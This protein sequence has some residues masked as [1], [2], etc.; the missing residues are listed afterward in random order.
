MKRR[1]SGVVI[2]TVSFFR[3]TNSVGDY[4]RAEELLQRAVDADLAAC[5]RTQDA[6]SKRF[7]TTAKTRADLAELK[8]TELHFTGG[9]EL[10]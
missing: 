9:R 10:S 2:A 4:R 7:L 5:R 1:V 3:A 6:A 8:L